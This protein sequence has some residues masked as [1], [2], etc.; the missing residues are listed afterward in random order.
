MGVACCNQIGRYKLPPGVI[1]MTDFSSLCES[2]DYKTQGEN[3]VMVLEGL[4]SKADV[5]NGNKRMYPSP[6]LKMACNKLIPKVNE[7]AVTGELGH[8]ADR[9]ESLPQLESHVITE[10]VWNEAKKEVYGKAEVL[11]YGPGTM[12]HILEQRILHKIKTGISS[13]A[14]GSVENTEVPNVVR[15]CEDLEIFTYDIVTEPSSPGS[16]V[17]L[18]EAL[19]YENL[20]HELK[21]MPGC[22]TFDQSCKKLLREYID[23]EFAKA[24][25]WEN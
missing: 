17:S 9:L 24:D 14:C 11:N 12:G 10:V 3:K 21:K 22:A 2:F 5:V 23:R 8:P 19:L 18:K 13:R 4:F 25:K 15:V 6:V 20:V 7:R 16:W 1:V